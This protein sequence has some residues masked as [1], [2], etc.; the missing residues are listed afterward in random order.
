[1]A[2]SRVIERLVTEY[3]IQIDR[4]LADLRRMEAALASTGR[5][6][7][8]SSNRIQ[9]LE[10]EFT[11]LQRELAGSRRGVDDLTGRLDELGN[12]SVNLG[13]GLRVSREELRR[14]LNEMNRGGRRSRGFREDLNNAR[15]SASLFGTDVRGL[16]GV[17]Q[18][19]GYQIQD[20]TVQLAGG[21]NMM[22]VFAQQGSQMASLF[23]P[24]GAVLGSVLAIAGALGLVF[25][26]DL[27]KSTSALEDFN[28]TIEE[29]RETIGDDNAGVRKLTDE[30][31]ELAQ[32]SLNAAELRLLSA[33]D[34][35]LDASGEAIETFGEVLDEAIGGFLTTGFGD[36]NDVVPKIKEVEEAFGDLE[37]AS[38]F[39]KFST[40][41]GTVLEE[42]LAHLLN[43]TIIP[44]SDN[45]TTFALPI[46]KALAKLQ[47]EFDLSRKQALEF[48]NIIKNVRL[49]GTVGELKA[50]RE[51]LAA[52]GIATQSKTTF[53]PFIARLNDAIT[54]VL[55][56]RDEVGRLRGDLD[57]FRDGDFPLQ[58]GKE[59]RLED[60]LDKLTAA[61]SAVAKAEILM[62]DA[63]GVV[64]EAV[65]AG[66][67]SPEEGAK[68]LEDYADSLSESAKNA[69]K[70]AAIIGRLQGRVSRLSSVFAEY[71]STERTLN[72]ILERGNV[73]KT[74]YAQI[75]S[76]IA[77]NYDEALGKIFKFSGDTSQLEE[78]LKKYTDLINEHL[79]GGLINPNQA[80][81][82]F[83]VLEDGFN[84]AASDLAKNKAGPDAAVL[85]NLRGK[86]S[87]LVKVFSAYSDAERKLIPIMDRG[88]ATREDY[89][90][91]L[92]GIVAGYNDMLRSVFKFS[93]NPFAFEDQFKEHLNNIN[94]ELA[95]GLINPFQAGVATKSLT[96]E[97]TE[98]IGNYA[99][100]TNAVTVAMEEYEGARR[101]ATIAERLGLDSARDLALNARK[102]GESLDEVKT[103]NLELL[104]LESPFDIVA[105]GAHA[106]FT[107]VSDVINVFGGLAK[108]GS[109]AYEEIDRAS[110]LVNA[111][112]R[113]TEAIIVASTGNILAAISAVVIAAQ[114][115]GLFD[116]G[117]GGNRKLELALS[118]GAGAGGVFGDN[119]AVAE[120]IANSTELTASATKELVSI[121]TDLRD[122][123]RDL[124]GGITG[125]SS[126]LLRSFSEGSGI[127]SRGVDAGPGPLDHFSSRIIL[128]GV[129]DT[130][131]TMLDHFSSRIILPFIDIVLPGLGDVV[132]K[133]IG[134]SVEARGFGVKID[135]QAFDTAI[136]DALA[137]SFQVF[138]VNPG[139]FGGGS[140]TRV[141]EGDL[142]PESVAEIQGVFALIGDAIK[143][144]AG[145]LGA[146]VDFTEVILAEAFVDL[147][148]K[149]LDEQRQAIED[150][151]SGVF[152]SVSGELLPFL[153]ELKISGETAGDTL[154][155]LA[156]TV[157][158]VADV[159]NKLGVTISELAPQINAADVGLLGFRQTFVDAA[160]GVSEL[161]RNTS[162][163]I[164]EFHS[165][166]RRFEI[167]SE[168]FSNVL[169]DLTGGSLPDGRASFVALVESL[170]LTSESSAK[171]AGQLTA[172]FDL[173]DQYFDLLEER[174]EGVT[175]ALEEA[176]ERLG[177]AVLGTA[178][179]LANSFRAPEAAITLFSDKLRTAIGSFATAIDIEGVI[180]GTRDEFVEFFNSINII[181]KGSVEEVANFSDAM[182]TML[183]TADAFFNL[184][185]DR[186]STLD[187]ENQFEGLAKGIGRR[188]LAV[189]GDTTGFDRRE[190]LAGIDALDDIPERFRNVLKGMLDRLF[191]AEDEAVRAQRDANAE[192]IRAEQLL[193][194]ERRI[195]QERGNEALLREFER[196]Q[197]LT[198]IDQ[199]DGV[200]DGIK[201]LLKDS[202]Q[203]VFDVED[204]VRRVNEA[205][206]L[207]TALLSMEGDLLDAQGRSYEALLIARRQELSALS[208]QEE[209]LQSLIFAA[210]DAYKTEALTIRLLQAQGKGTEALNITRR[211]ELI[212]LSAGDQSILRRIHSLEDLKAANDAVSAVDEAR[213]NLLVRLFRT[214]GDEARATQLERQLERQKT[215]ESLQGIL[216]EIYYH[217]DL[218]RRRD[219]L[220]AELGSR[221]KEE[222]ELIKSVHDTR[223]DGLN[224]E[225]GTARDTVEGI[226]G[227]FESVS[228]AVESLS[229]SGIDARVN[230]RKQAEEQLAIAVRDVSAGR[231]PE[232]D[233]LKRTIDTLTNS[234][235]GQFSSRFDFELSQ[236][237]TKAGLDEI[238][239]LSGNQL[240]DAE[241]QVKLLNE[242]IEVEKSNFEESVARLDSYFETQKRTLEES[243]DL[244]LSIQNKQFDTA[245]KS[246]EYLKEIDDKNLEL[247]ASGERLQERS[248]YQ[249]SLTER[250]IDENVQ[251][252]DTVRDLLE[253]LN[254]TG[255]KN[256]ANSESIRSRISDWNSRGLPP[257]RSA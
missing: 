45:V 107:D 71:T 121:N 111:G 163:F 191:D 3:A 37:R 123:F 42:G 221:V 50:A 257:E 39:E 82:A 223:I 83:R 215:D 157:Q 143:E 57:R 177:N 172:N 166:G 106:T 122:V 94:R 81:V 239:R 31:K 26:P 8:A 245:I 216:T 149:T 174:Q 230:L 196:G 24:G 151:F 41:F 247:I 14:M 168:G 233:D 250:L 85:D 243:R 165:E 48:L 176:N 17:M 159:A 154:T 212:A 126:T 181:P 147:K 115:F 70:D 251:L 193:G 213:I 78:S 155:R 146:S 171:A 72:E 170:D 79:S 118:V 179:L 55:V 30:M 235:R 15:R 88:N 13:G 119:S 35:Q 180:S 220:L 197:D 22:L 75:L 132:D 92:Q 28:K 53:R 90:Q 188:L 167:V 131:S 51:E 76:G 194:H 225:L 232:A 218:N 187:I 226:R 32:A 44:V 124:G 62:R 43:L 40:T 148:G 60:S 49:A 241:L 97:F 217:E 61:S 74:K 23:G 2:G 56:A 80:K 21:Q 203:A 249:N 192:L 185:E 240:S 27:F 12:S 87:A 139:P 231:L 153:N 222:R 244:D 113:L 169:S 34:K 178:N 25:L 91:I 99:K 112:M 4:A 18:G 190:E 58:T 98:A 142:D 162:R 200:S 156:T 77:D 227:V 109:G 86:M 105:Q 135:Q 19:F 114:S 236:A 201:D 229:V 182:N 33:I 136:N 16:R 189:T 224:E 100:S 96:S 141:K 152:G 6:S 93:G 210:Q 102:L 54:R 133:L 161:A 256:A 202:L 219:E 64:N 130:I 208:G 129:G 150:Y 252:R 214:S 120:S 145:I 234:D 52:F 47:D 144:G 67:R 84:K 116:G 246:G 1:M 108:A 207:R 164:D 20:V 65:R 237:K 125:L 29:V 183:V 255:A 11:R 175:K 186:S 211:R 140:K 184:V 117:G 38:R 238:A 95:E 103:A 36:F 248:E 59:K 160:G 158:V 73:T 10:R 198:S 110:K 173:A 9:E 138:R 128:P 89:S 101:L 195:L 206:R 209:A 63:R 199:L 5:S 228:R 204:E 137:R 104:K 242:A 46:R 253:A 205:E 66:L 134:G 254:R 68:I 127:T 7:D 69:E